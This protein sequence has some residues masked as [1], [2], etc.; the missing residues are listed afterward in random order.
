MIAPGTEQEPIHPVVLAFGGSAGS[1]RPLLEVVHDL[2]EDL[3]ASVLV[4]IHVGEQTRLPQILSRS[5]PLR[6]AFAEDQEA[7][8]PGRI[9]IAPRGQHLLARDGLA[10]LSPGPLVNR[11]RPAVDVMFASA[12][13]WVAGRTVAVVLSGALDD[14]AVGAALVDLAGGQVLVQDPMEAEFVGMPTAALAAAAGARAVPVRR[15]SQEIRQCVRAV[16][17]HGRNPVAHRVRMKADMDM[18]DS[19][20]PAFLREGETRL[21]RLTCPECGGGMAQV[22]LPQISY[23]RCHVG[24]QFSPQ[25]LAEAQAEAVEKKLWSAVAALEEQ[26]SV[27]RYLQ[28]G[29]SRQAELPS[30]KSDQASSPQRRYVDEVASRAEAL[31]S[32]VRAWSIHPPQVGHPQE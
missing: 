30:V 32:Q 26:T 19:D 21:T 9:Y 12:A 13:E 5:G 27:L 8:E 17:S 1:V 25:T 16:R 20:D 4:T 15:L 11:H 24:H 18:I 7:L 23:F 28:R 31:R 14:G 22:D 6:A 2:P 29:T 3:P 10:L